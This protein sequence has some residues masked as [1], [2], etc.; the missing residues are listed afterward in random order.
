MAAVSL[1]G[2]EHDPALVVGEE[3]IRTALAAAEIAT[4]DD[5]D[6]AHSVIVGL[7]R[8]FDYDALRRAARA[9]AAGAAFIATNDDRT[10]PSVGPDVP[11]AGALLAAIE[12]ASG[13]KAIVAGKPHAAMLRC[14]ASLLGPGVTWVVGDRPETDI[15]FARAGSWYG[16]LV[17]SGVTIAADDILERWTPD[18]VI[19]SVAGL[20]ELLSQ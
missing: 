9:A 10:F 17:L 19:P 15:A 8:R 4:T 12:A 6:E 5:P 16:V 2:T 7:D 11:G 18:L 13:R 3:G 1:L 14:V 20:P